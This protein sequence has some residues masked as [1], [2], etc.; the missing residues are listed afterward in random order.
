MVIHMKFIKLSFLILCSIIFIGCNKKESGVLQNSTIEKNTEKPSK[1]IDNITDNK[2]SVKTE[3]D[4]GKDNKQKVEKKKNYKEALTDEELEHVEQLARK[5]YDEEFPYDLTDIRVADNTHTSYD[6]YPEIE[7]G[8][9]IIFEVC[10]TDIG[11]NDFLR[12]IIF[13]RES[14]DGEWIKINQ[15]V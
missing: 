6:S 14:K 13:A 1:E 3:I 5:F 7:A 8:N 9:I 4:G 2:E 15:G 11:D 10:T 12:S